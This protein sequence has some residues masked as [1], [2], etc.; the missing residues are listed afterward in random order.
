MGKED[1][2]ASNDALNGITFD[3]KGRPKGL[4]AEGVSPYEEPEP[5]S[6]LMGRHEEGCPYCG[7]GP[8]LQQDTDVSS[9]CMR[10][11]AFGPDFTNTIGVHHATRA[12]HT[13]EKALLAALKKAAHLITIGR[14]GEC[15]TWLS[16][17]DWEHPGEDGCSSNCGIEL[18]IEEQSEQCW[19]IYLMQCGLKE[20]TDGE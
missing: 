7:A 3:E 10:C 19:I 6:E 5:N 18:G 17:I 14:G 2:Y 12:M 15:P 4:P 20:V 8:K 13:R 1:F 9:N 16:G 11:N